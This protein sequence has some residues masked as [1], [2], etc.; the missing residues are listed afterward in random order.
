[1]KKILLFV[2]LLIFQA[3]FCADSIPKDPNEEFLIQQDRGPEEWHTPLIEAITFNK[4]NPIQTVETLLKENADPNHYTKSGKTALAK[5]I[6]IGHLP[7]VR[8]LVEKHKV[9]VNQSFLLPVYVNEKIEQ[10]EITPLALAQAKAK[11]EQGYGYLYLPPRDCDFD[12]IIKL[13]KEH[14]AKE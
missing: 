13:L 9:N 6:L 12:K 10:R 5:A 1:M 7:I 11:K 2:P 8:L 14:G 4:R 3:L